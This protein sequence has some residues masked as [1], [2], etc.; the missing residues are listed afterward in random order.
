MRKIRFFWILLALALVIVVQ[1]NIQQSAEQLYQAGIYAEEVDGDLQ[2]AIQIYT[3][4]VENFG[5]KKEMAADAQLH[6]GLCYEKL[7]RSEAIKAYEQVL[8]NYGGQAKQVAAARER[9]A[10][11]QT[12]APSQ[13][14]SVKILEGPNASQARMI[15]PDGTKVLITR[16]DFV[17]DN[18]YVYDLSSKRLDNITKYVWENGDPGASDPR[19][20]PDGKE[21]V[22]LRY[23]PGRG[24]P[25]EMA[26][27]DL[28]GH[29]RIIY[30]VNSQKEG[31]PVPIAWMPDRS[32]ILTGFLSPNKTE[33][34]GLIP[35]SGGS[36]KELH[37]MNGE[38]RLSSRSVD[39]S[40]DGRFIAFQDK[41]S[42]GNYDIFTIGTDGRSLQVLSD[43]PADEGS[44]RWSPDG[45]HIVFL[46][47]RHGRRALWGI[48][49]MDGKPAGEAFFI[50]EGD[51][52]LINWTKHGLAYKSSLLVQ[53]IF[54]VPID[55]DALEF[56]GKPRQIEYAPTGGNVCP[57]WSP[58]GKH[59][60][61]VSFDKS[62][63]ESKIVIMSA[64]GG[65]TQEFPNPMKERVPLA[66]HDLRW[67]PDS[68]GLSL[69]DY[70]REAVE[71][72]LWQLDIETRK[73]KE[74]PIPVR[75]WT[76]TEWSKDGKSFLYLRQ[77]FANG[78][79]GIIERNPETGDERYVYRPTKGLGGV[80]RQLKFSRDFQKLVFTVGSGRI[81]L[82]DM[83]SGENRLLGSELSGSLDWSPDAKHLISAGERNKLGF[84]SAL[85]F[86][87]VDDG[88]EKKVDLGFSE[89][90]TF[91]D[92]SWS[93]DGKRI[94]F[95]AQSQILELFLMKNVISK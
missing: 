27:T 93:P 81:M 86:L 49:V 30:R 82:V 28:E 39:V 80:M 91:F 54:T 94:A 78:N 47:E 48:A 92:P 44:P 50:K 79:P 32:A 60:A 38:V 51:F 2:K 95:M 59:L 89:G 43:H 17:G 10:A 74:W 9:L 53:D 12:A 31:Y 35:V 73:W 76:R 77:G 22:F 90:T 72:T 52:G 8:E 85:F 4:I 65:E 66:I 5:D 84:P 71:Q 69:S 62:N 68:G 7:G 36:F 67:L 15:S 24:G 45:K 16:D 42:K 56:T 40:S 46:S 41:N 21:I 88:S 18:V 57:S 13:I 26:V 19:W 6:I 70:E 64:E 29:M 37:T 14:S 20:S 34:L 61:F 75:R 63:D 11:L 23:S 33:V 1:G 58:D 55:P 83:E 25:A 3:Q 87:S